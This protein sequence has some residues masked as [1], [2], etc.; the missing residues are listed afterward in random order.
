MVHALFAITLVPGYI[1]IPESLTRIDNVRLVRIHP[2]LCFVVFNFFCLCCLF[3]D[4]QV[5]G[6]T[7]VDHYGY[8]AYTQ[9]IYSI[10]VGYFLWDS[11]VCIQYQW[12]VSIEIRLFCLLTC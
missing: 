3:P 11:I 12:Y 7:V 10:S 6:L 8:D 4:V 9:F 2:L 5:T 1:W